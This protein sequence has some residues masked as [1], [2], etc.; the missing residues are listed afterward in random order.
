MDNILWDEC[1]DIAN[2]TCGGHLTL[3]KFTTNWRFML[4]TPYER[5]CIDKAYVGKTANEAM[6]NFLTDYHKVNNNK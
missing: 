2:K 1:V 4:D 3:Y 6:I 5:A